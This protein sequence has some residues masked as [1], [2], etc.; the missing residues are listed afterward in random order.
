MRR[1]RVRTPDG[2][3]GF[4]S[5]N[6]ISKGLMAGLVDLDD[7]LLEGDSPVV[8]KVGDLP[9]LAHGARKPPPKDGGGVSKLLLGAAVGLGG[10][11]IIL[12]AKGQYTLAVVAALLTTALLTRIT[13]AAFRRKR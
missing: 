1:Y 11:A 4:D 7:E 8:K 13:Q 9:I 6:E 3:V 10:A 2:E 5:L 12:L